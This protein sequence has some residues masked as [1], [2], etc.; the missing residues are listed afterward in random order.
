MQAWVSMPQRS[1]ERSWGRVS[2]SCC[3]AGTMLKQVLASGRRPSAPSSGTVGPRPSGYC[4]VS[5]AGTSSSLATC[6]REGKPRPE[7]EG[8]ACGGRTSG[9]EG[10]GAGGWTPRSE[11]GG[12]KGSGFLG[13]REE[14][15]GVWTPGSE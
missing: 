9:S 6:V 5:T 8:G 11:G 1:T 15:L 13:L 7:P 10:G 2:S 4:S 3:T 14:G 12:A